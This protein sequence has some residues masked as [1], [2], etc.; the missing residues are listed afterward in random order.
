MYMRM[1]PALLAALLLSAGLAAPA[2]A[3]RLPGH[4]GEMDASEDGFLSWDEVKGYLPTARK[5]EFE[6]ID[7]NKDGRID[8]GEWQASRTK[9]GLVR[10]NQESEDK[11][12]KDKDLKA[13]GRKGEPTKPFKTKEKKSGQAQAS[14]GKPGPADPRKPAPTGG[15]PAPKAD[16]R[17]AAAPAPPAPKAAGQSALKS[18]GA[19]AAG[20]AAKPEPKGAKAARPGGPTRPDQPSAKGP[21]A[22]PEI[23][24]AAAVKADKAAKAESGPAGQPAAQPGQRLDKGAVQPAATDKDARQRSGEPQKKTAEPK[25]PAD[26]R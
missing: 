20:P 21:A 17:P 10:D 24:P 2:G 6:A 3:V 22:K 15:K 14:P 9:L 26:Q 16:A 1:I 12:I 19:P 23:K 5:K 4:F 18:T 11:D 7:K 25:T 8:Y 13:S